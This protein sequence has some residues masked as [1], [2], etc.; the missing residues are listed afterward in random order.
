MEE[1]DYEQGVYVLR[2]WEIVAVEKL[3]KEKEWVLF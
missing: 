3:G 1:T 2:D